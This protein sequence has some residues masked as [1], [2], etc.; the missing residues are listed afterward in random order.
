MANK[1]AKKPTI[2][3][4]RQKLDLLNKFKGVIVESSL[5][6]LLWRGTIKPTPLS[7]SYSVEVNYRIGE[8]P[9]VFVSGDNLK[10]LNSPSFPHHFEIFPA[11]NKVEICLYRYYEF[12]KKDFLSAT[13]IPWTI[14][15]LYFYEI[16][17]STGIW[18]GGGEHPPCKKK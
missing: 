2:T 16:W 10:N 18:C 7:L 12:T 14:E 15:W 5:N 3:I 13:I 8:H 17:L 9:I 4:A 1:Y 11:E 6:H